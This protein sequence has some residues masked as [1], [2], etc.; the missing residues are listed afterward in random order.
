MQVLA[1]DGAL[2]DVRVDGSSGAAIVLIA[3]FPLTRE[4][5]ETQSA[6]LSQRARVVRPNL[7][8]TGE[9][10]VPEGPYLMERLAADVAASLDALGVERAA[11]AGHS[12]GGYVAM[13]FARMF[14]ERVT[15]LA[16]I[17]SRLAADTPDQAAA[18]RDLA[19]RIERESSMN[20]AVEAYAPR[21]TAPNTAE[22]R[23]DVVARVRTIAASIAPLGAA[24]LLRGM[25]MRSSSYDIAPELGIPVLVVAG[26]RDVNIP[27]EEARANA[28][29]FQRGHLVLCDRSGHV[30]MLEQPEALDAALT[31]WLNE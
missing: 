5:W 4:I 27:I 9:T 24:A 28:G 2:V 1:D 7:R 31:A 3:G 29:A 30:P 23:P 14:T 26:G 10:D 8:G 16:L 21:L 15:H 6:L 22:E 25:A 17:C 11:I 19:D 18:R 13:A 20:A 12:L